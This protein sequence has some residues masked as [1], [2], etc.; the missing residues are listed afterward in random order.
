MAASLSLTALLGLGIGGFLFL[1]RGRGEAALLESPPLTAGGA[2]ASGPAPAVSPKPFKFAN[3]F[4]GERDAWARARESLY[5]G[6]NA[7]P[8]PDHVGPCPPADRA[9]RTDD[10]RVERRGIMN[11][12]PTWWHANGVI[13]QIGT[14]TVGGKDTPGFMV[15]VPTKPARIDMRMEDP[16]LGQ[17]TPGSKPSKP[18]K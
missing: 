10:A 6:E 5:P 3:A 11:G 16:L 9:N 14:M 13:T 1:S 12:L 4:D 8:D 7:I 18:G 15:A 2:P 17:E